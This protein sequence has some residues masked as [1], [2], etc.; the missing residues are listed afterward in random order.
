MLSRITAT[1]SYR[2]FWDASVEL[3]IQFVLQRVDQDV[4]VIAG[5]SPLEPTNDEMVQRCRKALE[6]KGVSIFAELWKGH[7]EQ[8]PWSIH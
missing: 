6:G 2:D 8:G 3:V 4:G 1:T 5:N 7:K